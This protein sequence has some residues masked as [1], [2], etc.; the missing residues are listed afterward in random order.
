[1]LNLLGCSSS[2]RF[3]LWGFIL[4]H[5]LFHQLFIVSS[6][7]FFC[8]LRCHSFVFS[9]QILGWSDLQICRVILVAAVERVTQGR[10]SWNVLILFVT[11]VHPQFTESHVEET[12]EALSQASSKTLFCCSPP[13]GRPYFTSQSLTAEDSPSL[14]CWRYLKCLLWTELKLASL[15]P[16]TQPGKA[17][18]GVDYSKYRGGQK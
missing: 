13:L 1:M 11:N 3:L 7:R 8:F 10:W 9:S 2:C 18:I 5:L 6:S 16:K 4:G 17:G 12:S 15:S 14:Y